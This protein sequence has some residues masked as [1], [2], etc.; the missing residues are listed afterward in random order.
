MRPFTQ[1]PFKPRNSPRRISGFERELVYGEGA[2]GVRIEV[3]HPR[4]AQDR[5]SADTQ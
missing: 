3:G 2:S 1:A 5:A 4:G